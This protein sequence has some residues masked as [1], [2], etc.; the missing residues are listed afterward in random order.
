MSAEQRADLTRFIGASVLPGTQRIYS[1]HWEAWS[2]F[3]ARESASEDAFLHECSEAEKAALVGLFL[4]RRYQAG[5]RG[6]AATAVTAGI[7]MRFAQELVPT[8]FL[9]SATI[10]T[11]RKAC[12]HTP[13]ELRQMRDAGVSTSVKLPVCWSLLE[14]MRKRLWR[15]GPWELSH[16]GNCMA[17]VGCAWGFDQ[18]A[19]ISEYTCPEPGG[20]DHCIRLDDLTFVLANGTSVTGSG[21]RTEGMIFGDVVECRA[22]AASSKG[23][24]VVKAKVLGRRS[25]EE[26]EYLE[27]LMLFISRS[28]SNGSDELFSYRKADGKK[29][30]LRAR[31][32][33][34]E[35]KAEAVSAGLPPDLFSSHSLRKGSI[36]H[37]RATGASEDDRRDRGGYAPD[38]QIMHE[39]Y[40][41]VSGLGALAAS[42]LPQARVPDA[43]DVRRLI[44]AKRQRVRVGPAARSPREPRSTRGRRALRKVGSPTALGDVGEGQQGPGSL[45]C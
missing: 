22:L 33:R 34:Q 42:G 13:R 23:K 1:A 6:K 14:Q 40:D 7:R 2:S 31:T 5:A 27:D 45:G 15:E 26:T 19:R 44:P 30:V 29:L 39:T 9:G 32:V 17:Y 41:Y 11:A 8:E 18:A 4:Y 24:A 10:A 25:P 28:R 35:I 37:M 36:T 38:S 12:K 21:L 16:F 3:V 43:T 20:E